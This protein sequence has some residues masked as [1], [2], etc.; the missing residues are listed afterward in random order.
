[1]ANVKKILTI[2]DLVNFCK[3]N[4]FLSFSAKE[5]GYQLAV[6]VPTTFEVVENVDE[7]H[8]GMLRL[9]F[10]IFHTGRNRNGS[11][12]SEDSAKDAMKTIA[13]RPILA[14][15]H[16]LDNGEYDFEGHEM[17]II[18][19][20][21]GEKELKY[22]EQQVGSFSSEPAFWEHDDELDKD[23]VCAYGYISEEY[24][25]TADIIRRKNGTKNS[26]ELYIDEMA[27]DAKEGCLN[28]VK[29]F[30]NGS[31]LLGSHSDGT[32]IGE[33]MLGSRADIADFSIDN[34][35][36]SNEKL[37]SV[38]QEL[39]ESLDNYNE[40]FRKEELK[41][42]NIEL[43]EEEVIEE[44]TTEE[45]V[46]E[47]ETIIE[48]T[49]AENEEIEEPVVEED[50]VDFSVTVNGETKTFSVS[51]NDKLN[52]MYSLINETY[53]EMDNDF[54]DVVVYDETKL[55]EF[56]GYFTGKSFRQTYKV[57]K[58]VYSLVGDRCEIFA[59]YMTAEEIEAFENMKANYSSIETK[60]N[61]YEEE[62]SKMEILNSSDYAN[63]ASNEE[64][65][66][67]KEQTNHFELTIDEVRQKAD[68]IL[69]NCAK[70]G[71]LNFEYEEHKDILSPMPVIQ[72]KKKQS[73]YGNIFAEK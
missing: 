10:R 31:T 61:R 3:E 66:S 71:S 72:T 4:N 39:K 52:A 55:C 67:L 19:N 59:K 63:I 5:S 24:T 18:E 49:P 2:D 15:I 46:V 16:Q 32:E 73:R 69:L 42:D 22:I 17:E 36:Y 12:V 29:F 33:G 44:V 65:E 8:R 38:M 30:V 58:D 48:E 34:N 62:P 27:F 35:S 40:N 60:L 28:L 14:A 57:K 9:K 13:D 56:H 20:E 1:M 51:L 47:E 11:F 23:Y 45:V 43:N 50:K 7:N 70:Q 64:F 6:K 68:E 41:V 37:I 53:G 25:K 21:D 26:C 54:Y